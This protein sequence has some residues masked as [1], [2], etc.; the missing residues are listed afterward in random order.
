MKWNVPSFHFKPKEVSLPTIGAGRNQVVVEKSED[1][2]YS[3]RHSA[4]EDHLAYEGLHKRG[5]KSGNGY[6]IPADVQR[7]MSDMRFNQKRDGKNKNNSRVRVYDGQASHDVMMSIPKSE[8]LRL[9]E[10]TSHNYYND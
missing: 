7:S 8:D 3:V 5:K 6:G 1:S 9:N 2:E 10:N 4:D